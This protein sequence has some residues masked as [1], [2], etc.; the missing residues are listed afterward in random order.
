MLM[1]PE[2]DELKREFLAEARVKVDEIERTLSDE[3]DG[4]LS[5]IIYLAHQLKGAGGSYGFQKISTE[6]AEIERVAEN[7]EDSSGVGLQQIRV[8]IDSLREEI[9][10]RESE[11]T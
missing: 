6:A 7:S 5:R 8:R 3:S 1:D 4:H 2:F 11:L 9:S 10:A